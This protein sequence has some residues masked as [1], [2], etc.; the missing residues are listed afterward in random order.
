VLPL[1]L[2]FGT[3]SRRALAAAAVCVIAGGFAQLYVLIIG[4]QAYPQLM[5]PEKEVVSSFFDGVVAS[6]TP[7]LPEVALGVGGVALALALTAV[8][9]KVL[10]FLPKSLADGEVGAAAA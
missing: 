7:S 10:P 6:Y 9:L 8:A 1:V 2:L 5:F 4:G 3:P